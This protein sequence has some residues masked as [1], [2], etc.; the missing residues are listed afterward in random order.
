MCMMSYFW[1]R[2][3][4]R[5]PYHLLKIAGVLS[6]SL[7]LF[8]VDFY[9]IQLMQSNLKYGLKVLLLLV[10]VGVVWVLFFR[11]KFGFGRA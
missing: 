11:G 3:H 2:K 10:Y 9:G 6:L 1:G 8:F 5:V 7:V 4:Y